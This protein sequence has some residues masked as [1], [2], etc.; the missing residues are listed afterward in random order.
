MGARPTLDHAVKSMDFR[1]LLKGLSN[2]G[3]ER[4]GD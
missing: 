2:G 3:E 4:G 1:R